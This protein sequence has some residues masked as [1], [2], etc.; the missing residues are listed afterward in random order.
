MLKKKTAVLFVEPD[1]T[2]TKRMQ[3]PTFVVTHWKKVLGSFV[4]LTAIT[5]LS[6]VYVVKQRTSEKYIKVYDQKINKL[7]AENRLLELDEFNNQLTTEEIKKSFNSID[8]T[9]DR[10]NQKMKKRGLKEIKMNPNMGGPVEKGEDDLVELSAFY[11]K[12]LEDLEAKLDGLPLG[13]P[14]HGRITSPYGYRRNPFTNRGREMHQGVDLKG[15]TGD[16]V[17][18]T[19]KGKVSFAGWKGAYGYVVMVKHKNGYETRYAHLTRTRVKKGQAVE[20]GD[21]VGLLGS[22]GRSTGPHLHYE[23]LLNNR[24]LNPSTYF[25]L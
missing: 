24:K 20:A 10:I 2:S 13:R 4:A 19:A 7:K 12:Q 11:K 8:S 5:V 6:V 18:V 3:V 25:S 1:G 23:V 21:I 22:T 9:I 16:P 14:H 15:R 17:K